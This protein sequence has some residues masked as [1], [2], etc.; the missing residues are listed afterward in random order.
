MVE[1]MLTRHEPPFVNSSLI[2]LQPCVSDGRCACATSGR[3]LAGLPP[4]TA[5]RRH[6]LWVRI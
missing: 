1:A 4:A 2:K 3:H 6:F 5:P